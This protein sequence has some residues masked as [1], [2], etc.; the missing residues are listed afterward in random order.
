MD[1]SPLREEWVS[2]LDELLRGAWSSGLPASLEKQKLMLLLLGGS[3]LTSA[4]CPSVLG[5]GASSSLQHLQ[6]VLILAALM[7]SDMA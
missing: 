1:D 2:L 3:S 7:V 6:E 4:K 5:W